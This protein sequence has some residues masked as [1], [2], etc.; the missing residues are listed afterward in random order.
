MAR[1]TASASI[2]PQATVQRPDPAGPGVAGA[3]QTDYNDRPPAEHGRRTGGELRAVLR[4][5]H[6]ATLGLPRSSVL[7]RLVARGSP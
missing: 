3:A 2:S 1:L 6:P 7:M 4:P 5:D